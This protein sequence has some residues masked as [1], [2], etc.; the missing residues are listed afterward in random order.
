MLH[1]PIPDTGSLLVGDP[2]RQSYGQVPL[3]LEALEYTVLTGECEEKKVF[4]KL[5][6]T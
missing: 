2:R 6:R 1:R 5:C 3:L 4:A